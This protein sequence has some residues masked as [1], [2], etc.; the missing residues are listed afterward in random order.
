VRLPILGL[1]NLAPIVAV[2]IGAYNRS[3]T[4]YGA[5]A[6]WV[7]VASVRLIGAE[8]AGLFR[9]TRRP[10]TGRLSSEPVA[11]GRT[12]SAWFDEPC[13]HTGPSGARRAPIQAR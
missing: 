3:Y 11:A 13:S 4:E 5:I 9:S 1:W 6:F 2:L 10:S 8:H 7:G 12:S